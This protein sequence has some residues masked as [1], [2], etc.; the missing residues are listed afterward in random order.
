[1]NR[2]FSLL[3]FISLSIAL[4]GCAPLSVQALHEPFY[5][6]S[7]DR[8]TFRAEAQS[9]RGVAEITIVQ[10]TFERQGFCAAYVA[11]ECLPLPTLSEPIL[12]VSFLANSS[13]T[14]SCT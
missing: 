5:P 14:F 12:A 8:V 9:T 10:R 3:A 4:S 11:G 6:S 1:M 2:F 7:A 13:C